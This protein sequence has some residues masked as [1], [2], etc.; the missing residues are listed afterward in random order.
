MSIVVP[1]SYKAQATIWL[2]YCWEWH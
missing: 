1:F 2:K